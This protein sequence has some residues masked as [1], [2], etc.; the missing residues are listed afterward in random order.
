MKD[1]NEHVILKSMD[2]KK[3]YYN[4]ILSNVQPKFRYKMR[5]ANRNKL[6]KSGHSI[7]EDL[8]SFQSF[9]KETDSAVNQAS[10]SSGSYYLRNFDNR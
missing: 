10:R 9:S 4:S 3:T 5:G 2:N 8:T 6:D 1:L 7:K